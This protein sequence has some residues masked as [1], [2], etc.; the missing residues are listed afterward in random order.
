MSKGIDQAIEFL[1]IERACLGFE[2][3]AAQQEEDYTTVVSLEEAYA[4]NALHI[5]ALIAE[6]R[7]VA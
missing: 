6:Q 5:D 2:I 3:D 1:M 4:A 7:V